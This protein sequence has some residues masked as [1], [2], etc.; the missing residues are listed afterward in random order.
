MFSKFFIIVLALF[1]F[2]GV[3]YFDRWSQKAFIT[4]MFSS[5][6]QPKHLKEK[7]L[8]NRPVNKFPENFLIGTSSSAY[9]IEG[10]WNEDGKTSSIWDD[11]VHSTPNAVVDHT[12]ADIGPDSYHNYQED[13]RA[14]KLVGVKYY[15]DNGYDA[16]FIKSFLSIQSSNTIASQYHGPEL[17]PVGQRL[18]RTALTITQ[19]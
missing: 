9:Q 14:L 11:F 1:A 13:I 3:Y 17:F 7:I 18:I 10:G 12:S 5:F 16:F 15:V 6:A 2:V 8:V 4:I 19:S